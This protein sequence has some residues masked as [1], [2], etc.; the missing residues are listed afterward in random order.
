MS[1]AQIYALERLV[2]FKAALHTFA[3]R[4][5]ADQRA[6]LHECLT[7]ILAG[8]HLSSPELTQNQEIA[9]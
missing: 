4:L 2:D 7:D 9:G 5:S 1:T 3:D 6:R 8:P